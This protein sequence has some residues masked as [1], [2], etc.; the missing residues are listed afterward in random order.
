MHSEPGFDQGEPK[1]HYDSHP[2][3]Q[4]DYAAQRMERLDANIANAKKTVMMGLIV[5]GLIIVLLIALV[6]I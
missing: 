3:T 4:P 6:F 2:R 5:G 1:K